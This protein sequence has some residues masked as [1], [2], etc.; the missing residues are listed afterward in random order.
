MTL[1]TFLYPVNGFEIQVIKQDLDNELLS[2]RGEIIKS[3][4]YCSKR[5]CFNTSIVYADP[6][7]FVHNGF[8]YLFY[9]E[10]KFRG[11][12]L[13]VM[14]KTND[15]KHWSRPL[16]VLKEGFHLSFPFV[17]EDSGQIWMVPETGH[18][19]SIRLYKANEDLTSFKFVTKLLE[20]KEYV[21]SSI[22]YHDGLF[23]LF[24]TEKNDQYKYSQRLFVSTSLKGTYKEHPCSPIFKGGEYGRNAGSII[25]RED[26]LFRP[27]QDCTDGYGNNVSLMKI[28]LLTPSEYKEEVYKDKVLDSSISYYKEGGHQFNMVE[29]NGLIIKATDAHYSNKRPNAGIIWTRIMKMIRN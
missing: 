8:L 28:I 13:L 12:G 18:D 9:E 25:K 21:D 5:I 19:N 2:F 26:T 23:Y 4:E 6:F 16:T 29:Y 11:K 20:G 22:V 10:M 17:F 3:V 14:T 1:E 27:T 24:T 15:L 7:L